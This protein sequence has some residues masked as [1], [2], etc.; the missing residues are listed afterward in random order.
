M[1]KIDARVILVTLAPLFFLI[2]S[3]S[4]TRRQPTER[5]EGNSAT[6]GPFTSARAH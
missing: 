4:Q 5:Q 6:V 2:L 3:L 1:N